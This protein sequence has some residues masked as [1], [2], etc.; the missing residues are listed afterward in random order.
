MNK[1]AIDHKL[2]RALGTLPL[3]LAASL[4]LAGE[5]AP[6]PVEALPQCPDLGSPG[7]VPPTSCRMSRATLDYLQ[8]APRRGW[9][10][11]E[12]NIDSQRLFVAFPPETNPFVTTGIVRLLLRTDRSLE[13]VERINASSGGRAVPT[14]VQTIDLDCRQGEMTMRSVALYEASGKLLAEEALPNAKPERILDFP[15]SPL[16]TVCRRDYLFSLLEN[17]EEYL[18][19]MKRQ[20]RAVARS[21]IPDRNIPAPSTKPAKSAAKGEAK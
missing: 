4:A 7:K 15:Q 1:K 17:G 3:A 19:A 8:S 16:A 11:L 6:L 5:P 21:A 14:R 10:E 18:L 2:K 13:E 20:A 9:V 12:S